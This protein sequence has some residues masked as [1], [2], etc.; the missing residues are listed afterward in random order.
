MA[1]KKKQLT[2]EERESL[3]EEMMWG[4]PDYKNIKRLLGNRR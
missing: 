2:E 3:R 4:K 1:E